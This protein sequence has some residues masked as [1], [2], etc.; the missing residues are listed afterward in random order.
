MWNDYLSPKLRIIVIN[1]SGGGI[2]RIIDGP[3]NET[4]M[5]KLFETRHKR[6]INGLVKAF[7]LNYF[8]AENREQ[9]EKTLIEF[10]K[11]SDTASV[12]EI[13]T[14]PELNSEIL[15]KYFQHLKS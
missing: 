14:N 12:L 13:K 2:F 3:D 10:Y 9:L 1:N 5:Q 8:S 15:K 11:P 6:E 7:G 4:E